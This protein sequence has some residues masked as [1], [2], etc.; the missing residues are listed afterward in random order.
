MILDTFLKNKKLDSY[1]DDWE[2]NAQQN[3]FYVILCDPKYRN[4]K[5]GVDDF[6]QTGEE[7]ITR[8]FDFMNTNKIHS[9]NVL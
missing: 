8:V 1:A 6:Y 5:W 2:M 4:N 7:E 3:A 9:N